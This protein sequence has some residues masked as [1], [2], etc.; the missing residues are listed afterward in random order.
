MWAVWSRI[1]NWDCSINFDRK[2]DVCENI[3][4]IYSASVELDIIGVIDVIEDV[5]VDLSFFV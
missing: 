5:V 3:K 4:E 1:A 2:E